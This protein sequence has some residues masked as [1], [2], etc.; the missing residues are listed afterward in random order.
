ML[1]IFFS[2]VSTRTHH[3]ATSGKYGNDHVLVLFRWL[4]CHCCSAVGA[5]PVSLQLGFDCFQEFLAGAYS[6]DRRFFSFGQEQVEAVPQQDH[7]AVVLGLLGV[8]NC[9]FLGYSARTLACYSHALALFAPHIQQVRMA[10]TSFARTRLQ[11]ISHLGY[12]LLL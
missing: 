3:F 7:L 5:V 4:S 11:R 2:I 12:V 8:W 1:L 6:L 9:S 10:R